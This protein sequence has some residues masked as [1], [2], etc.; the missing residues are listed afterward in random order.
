MTVREILEVSQGANIYGIIIEEE[1]EKDSVTYGEDDLPEEIL[2][3]EVKHLAWANQFLYIKVPPKKIPLKKLLPFL[4]GSFTVVNQ[5]TG[6]SFMMNAYNG[7][8]TT[9]ENYVISFIKNDGESGLT[10]FVEQEKEINEDE[11]R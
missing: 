1:G 8:P 7:V 2:D 6:R 4:Q 3:K 11:L 9:G 5:T 10:I